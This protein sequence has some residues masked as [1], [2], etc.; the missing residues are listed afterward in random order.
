MGGSWHG[1][2][3]SQCNCVP[4]GIC[5]VM[6]VRTCCDCPIIHASL[7]EARQLV[8]MLCENRILLI[9]HASPFSLPQS[10]GVIQPREP[11]ESPAHQRQNGLV[12]A[13]PY[14][15]DGRQAPRLL[16]LRAH[17]LEAVA[18]A[19]S[20]CVTGGLAAPVIMG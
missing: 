9:C 17:N 1:I 16:G 4:P 6:G 14:W 20:M 11:L 7:L 8:G 18:R 19:E 15:I 2:L 10:I 3:I 5:H 12:I 13:G